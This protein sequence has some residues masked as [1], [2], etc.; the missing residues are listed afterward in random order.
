MALKVSVSNVTT[1]IA[2]NVTLLASVANVFKIT[3]YFKI[4]AFK[5]IVLK[6]L[7]L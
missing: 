4:A 7:L 1:Q 5:E 6:E 3:S 2:Y